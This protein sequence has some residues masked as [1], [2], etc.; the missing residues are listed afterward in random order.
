MKILKDIRFWLIFGFLIR[1][2]GITNPPLE[3]HAWRQT[4][5]NMA[6]KNFALHN[7]NILY[8]T[9]DIFFFDM[10][11]T[12]GVSAMEFPIYNYSIAL[13]AKI[14][15]WSDWYG[16]LI[17]LIVSTLGLWAFFLII[18]E[19]FNKKLAEVSTFIL[20]LSIWLT[21]SRKI[22]PDTFSVSLA[23][24]GLYFGLKYLYELK[25]EAKNLIFF[26]LFSTIG[27]LAKI[28]AIY[29]F[30]VVPLYDKIIPLHKKIK[31]ILTGLIG[32]IPVYW[33]YFI[34]CPDLTVRFNNR[35]FFTGKG[36]VQGIIEIL[37]HLQQLSDHLTKFAFSYSGF[38]F[39][40]LG[41]FFLIKNKEK[42]IL[43]VIS[44]L[45]FLFLLLVCKS[46]YNFV[47]HNYY[48]IP[49]VPVLSLIAGYFLTQI[50]KPWLLVTLLIV[51][52][53]DNISRKQHDF[54]V[55]KRDLYRLTTEKIIDRFIA[56]T[57]LIAINGGPSPVDLYCTGRRGWSLEN[58]EINSVNLTELKNRGVSHLVINK[59]NQDFKLDYPLIFEDE[60]FKI[61]QL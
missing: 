40:L 46:G 54:R 41:L 42:K 45:S 8:P 22:M 34:W 29:L 50:K 53:A 14:F 20:M 52:A 27:I 39:F 10:T 7:P 15:G 33:W 19:H 23:M 30:C 4:I 51:F 2:I 49:F 43:A 17:N 11:S 18:K 12:A 36:I 24:I 31:L 57:Q 5:T 56:P 44:I 59:H 16:R 28:P 37:P 61:Y 38:V 9:V 55:P 58:K 25:H 35:M 3:S 26:F 6:A 32:L 21:F 13:A 1:L 60:D 47:H 48:I